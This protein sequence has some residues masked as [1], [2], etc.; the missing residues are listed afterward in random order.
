MFIELEG[1]YQVFYFNIKYNISSIYTSILK[2]KT[3]QY[4]SRVDHCFFIGNEWYYKLLAPLI[5]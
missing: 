4:M 2:I 5:F 3:Q 1:L